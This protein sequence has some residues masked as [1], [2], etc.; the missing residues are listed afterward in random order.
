MKTVLLLFVMVLSAAWVPN[1]YAGDCQK[2]HASFDSSYMQPA[3]PA[4]RV[5]VAGRTDEINLA[6][7]YGEHGHPCVGTGV[8][9]RAIQIGIR[10]LYGDTVPQRDD[11]LIF[12]RMAGPGVLDAIDRIMQGPLRLA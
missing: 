6:A 7:L 11:L 12:S 9:F 4:V 2:C 1:S 10:E 5:Q 3:L 8:A